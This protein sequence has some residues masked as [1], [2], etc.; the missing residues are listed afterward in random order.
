MTSKINR[1]N[2]MVTAG[3]ISL[4]AAA[5]P[6]ALAAENVKVGV[7]LPLT[8]I[9]AT[10]GN[11]TMNGAKAAADQINEKGGV[12]ALGGAKLELVFADSQSKPDIGA[13]EVER[14]IQR[15]GVVTV[16]GAYNSGV[17]FP[18]SEVAERYKTPWIVTGAVKDEITE[19]NFKYVFRPANKA[20][21]DAREQLDAIQMLTEEFG[22]G[23]KTIGLF[24]E[25]T[26][27]GRSHAANVKT[28]AAE[29]GFTIALDESYPP[30][31]VDFTAQILKIRS[32]RPDAL[33]VAAYTPDHILFSRQMFENRILIPFGIH[34][35]GGGAE[36]PAYYEAVPARANEYMFIQE[37]W[38]ID[39]LSNNPDPE[40]VEIN[41]R[42]RKLGKYDL[43]SFASQGVGAVY[44]LKDALERAASVDKEAI[45]AA[46]ADTD[47]TS[48]LALAQGF[49]RIKFDEQG[50]NTFAHGVISQTLDGQRLTI[51]PAESR[52][53]GVKPAWPVPEWSQR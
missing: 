21:Y 23:P 25:G 45:R 12:A 30:A 17:T 8:G 6:A 41:E 13:S 36:D 4:L 20:I 10:I 26:D 37:D 9:S 50:Q 40:L 52:A 49:D 18:A 19:R 51:W 3:A 28:L 15:E 53:P 34:T 42:Y 31:Q 11:Q 22:T 48:G 32:T 38:R 29:R 47:I 2:F 46:L 5:A 7:V 24:Y 1:R 44:L 35:V 16:L 39:S 33:I 43:N 14:L 27:W